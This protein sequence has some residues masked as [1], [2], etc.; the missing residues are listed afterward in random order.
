MKKKSRKQSLNHLTKTESMQTTTIE[1]TIEKPSQT[2]PTVLVAVYGTLKAGYGNHRVIESP[3]TK[4]ISLGVTEPSYKMISL[5]G[6]FPGL[7]PGD[8]Q[9]LVEVYEVPL[10][11]LVGR[12]DRL[13]GYPHMYGRSVVPI[14]ILKG[15]ELNEEAQC[16]IYTYNLHANADV[17]NEVLNTNSEGFVYWPQGGAITCQVDL[18]PEVVH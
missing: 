9:I 5:G 8:N 7:I 10:S 6:G 15:G 1:H 2:P 13:E 14:T 4:F 17:V 3:E 16:Y 11:L 12:L 18:T